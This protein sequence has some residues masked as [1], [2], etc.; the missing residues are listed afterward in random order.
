ML[1][2]SVRHRVLL[3]HQLGA[4]QITWQ[5]ASRSN[6]ASAEVGC[7]RTGRNEA[8]E[9]SPGLLLSP[10]RFHQRCGWQWVL[11]HCSV[12]FYCRAPRQRLCAGVGSRD[13]LELP[14]EVCSLGS[15]AIRI[16]KIGLHL[17]T[18]I[19]TTN[20]QQVK[21]ALAAPPYNLRCPATSP[22]IR[23]EFFLLFS[24][25][26]FSAKA[27]KAQP[28]PPSRCKLS[29]NIPLLSTTSQIRRSTAIAS[30]RPCRHAHP[31]TRPSSRYLSL[32]LL[33][34]R[35]FQPQWLLLLRSTSKLPQS[36]MSVNSSA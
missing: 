17:A 7:S 18:K 2:S 14:L 20:F 11:P 23:A 21:S 8:G 35:P 34:R 24:P 1:G 15:A 33:Q 5:S 25:F 3:L 4:V 9:L 10:G 26:I 22:K 13:C 27:L 12:F 16:R 31:R 29:T 19:W 32:C 6:I 36:L 30:H 28:Y